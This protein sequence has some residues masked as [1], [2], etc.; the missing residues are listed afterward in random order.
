MD[1]WVDSMSEADGIYVTD[2]GSTDGTVERMRR[3][4]VHVFCEKI[5]PF[6]F[7]TAR[8]I[9]LSHAGGRGHLRVHRCRRGL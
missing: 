1:R 2:T 5:E 6:R 3:R 9:A 8:N 7:D 4:G